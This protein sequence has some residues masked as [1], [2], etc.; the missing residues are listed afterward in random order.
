MK[1]Q[2][3]FIT[4][5]VAEW[6]RERVGVSRHYVAEKVNTKPQSVAHW[7]TET[8]RPTM[9][10]AHRLAQTLRIPFGYLF[11]STPPPETKLLPDFRRGT[12]RKPLRL[13]PDLREVI[14]DVL[15]K[16]EW[17]RSLLIEEDAALVELVGRFSQEDSTTEVAR[18]LRQ[19]LKIPAL[20][21]D[22]TGYEDFLRAL[23]RQ[24]EALGILVMR[25]GVVRGNNHRKLSTDEFRGFAISDPYAPLVFINGQD[26]KAAQVFTLPHELAHIAI[27]SSGISN[28]DLGSIGRGQQVEQFCNAVAAETLLPMHLLSRQW[29]ERA[30]ASTN[31]SR[32]ARL[33]RVSSLMTIRRA[34]DLHKLSRSVFESLYKEEERGLGG[35]TGAGG[36]FYLTLPS[37]YSHTLTRAIVT[38]ALN[39]RLSHRDAA[40][41]LAVRVDTLPKIAESLSVVW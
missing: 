7:E 32:I 30:T 38:A 36:N 2:R 40:R 6:A 5:K 35:Q 41:F 31:V 27:D 1:T 3:A 39:E 34:Y 15:V 10:Q 25:S 22:T 14:N 18:H 28:E 37:R 17:Y 24:T 21:R 9:R 12:A 33:N 8:A 26:F 11:L 29:N 16:Q 19:I 23:V 13:S 4:G 20:V